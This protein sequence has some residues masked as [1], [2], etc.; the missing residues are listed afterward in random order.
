[1]PVAAPHLRATLERQVAEAGLTDRVRMLSDNVHACLSRC[2]L[3]LVASGTA[4]LETAL[5]RVPMVVFYN[6][7][8]V[9]YAVARMLVK[10]RFIAMPNILLDDAVVPELIQGEF[11]VDRLVAEAEALLGDPAR[12]HAIR[13]RLGDIPKLLGDGNVLDRAAQLILAE[14]RPQLL[15][16]PASPSGVRYQ[17]YPLGVG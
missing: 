4:T 1:M 11:T 6:L 14:A 9:T 15:A 10:T 16:A 3:A 7:H 5:L 2:R 13:A 8:P 12:Q 17:P